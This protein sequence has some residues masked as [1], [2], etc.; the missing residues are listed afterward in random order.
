M[1]AINSPRNGKIREKETPPNI[2]ETE[3][4][5]I[6][7]LSL[8]LLAGVAL[9]IGSAVAGYL[10]ADTAFDRPEER[11]VLSIW[12][13]IIIL[14]N[15][16]FA[17]SLFN[18]LSLPSSLGFTTLLTILALIP[19]HS[20]NFLK[21]LAKTTDVRI[22]LGITAVGLGVAAYCSQVIV[23][24]DSGLYHLQ[25]IKW[26]SD[27][28]VVPGMALIHW[29][30]GISSSWFALAATFNQGILAGRM[31]TLPGGFCLMMLLLQAGIAASHLFRKQG[32]RQD[33]FMLCTTMLVIPL[34]L[35]W[36]MPN[37]PT[38]DLPVICL[39]IVTA[40]AILA[41]SQES[42]MTHQK[43]GRHI[44]LALIILAAG[45]ASMKLS[46][47]PLLAVAG[48]FYLFYRGFAFNKLLTGVA[49][50][51]LVLA[52]LAGA[53]L[54][55]TGCAFFPSTLFCLDVPWSLGQSVVAEKSRIIQEWAKWGGAP[56][57]AGATTWNWLI[58]W[59]RAEIVGSTL[60]LIT[61]ASAVF[62]LCSA[63]RRRSTRGTMPVI[64]IGLAGT[65]FMLC[66]APSWRF[67]LGYLSLLPA[68]V[69]TLWG[70]TVIAAVCASP[71]AQ[72]L[73][74]PA[75]F[76]AL[77]ATGIAL[78][79]HLL[80]RPSYKLLDGYFTG[81]PGI[82]GDNPHFNLILPPKAQNICNEINPAIGQ[83][84]AMTRNTLIEKHALDFI[85]YQP[86]ASE[87]CWDSPLPCAGDPQADK[88]D[89]IALR[90]R[91]LG[92]AGGFVQTGNIQ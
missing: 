61:L 27:I 46:A 81:N 17:I 85:Y 66:T 1:Y 35:I 67:G 58:P 25:Y 12:L 73:R 53:G 45:A 11:A 68:L 8:I 49:I 4:M 87:T 10:E 34:L 72:L 80:P 50:T 44:T 20:R 89:A 23:W 55:I 82:S 19:P 15:S 13:G 30:L 18:R 64:A 40:W 36:G 26:L 33:L 2:P 52:P 86:A 9:I 60:I 38:P 6:L 84:I 90:N 71:A 83:T 74:N 59:M 63:K 43:S 51:M 31:F 56:T 3:T 39:E 69:L 65:A 32:R 29:R 91:Q 28:G 16:F 21:Q 24:Y 79:S 47:A 7:F 77:V 48:L 70:E 22:S 14:A 57:P 62:I 92:I 54:L 78:H 5:F 41:I 88:P 75:L 37:S 76:G 42:P